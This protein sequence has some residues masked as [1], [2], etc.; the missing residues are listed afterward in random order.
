MT[1]EIL[2]K[3]KIS[4]K[5]WFKVDIKSKDECW[6]WLGYK[7]NWGYGVA[8][9]NDG[10]GGTILSHR[11]SYILTNEDI[12]DG[13]QVQHACN[14]PGCCNPQHLELGTNSKNMKYMVEQGISCIGEIHHSKLTEDQV[15]E[16]RKL[17]NEQR[18]LDPELK[19]WRITEP[20]AQRFG[21]HI[22]TVQ[23]IIRG[24]SWRHVKLK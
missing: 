8:C 24:E 18:R 11:L 9:L 6:N 1:E 19:Q 17:Y 14:N 4:K 20:I 22:T 23:R 12:P 7:D 2:W 16:I 15:R 10:K 3:N 13:L 21:I 5:F